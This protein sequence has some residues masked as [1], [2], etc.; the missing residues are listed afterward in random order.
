MKFF[1][2]LNKKIDKVLLYEESDY[3]DPASDKWTL[4]LI[5]IGMS[6]FLTLVCYFLLI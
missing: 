3:S 2:K 6:I 5:S 1:N 4:V